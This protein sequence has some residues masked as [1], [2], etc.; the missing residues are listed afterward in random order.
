MAG[1]KEML[2]WRLSASPTTP[3]PVS[4]P[5]GDLFELAPEPQMLIDP[6][7]DRVL[8]ANAALRALVACDADDLAMLSPRRLVGEQ[9]ADLIVFTE[10]VLEKGQAWSDGL[11]CCGLDGRV[12][13]VEWR[14]VR[15]FTDQGIA[16][17]VA[18]R[19]I[20]QQQHRQAAAEANE[21]VRRGL[22]E[23]RRVER[24]FQEIEQ[25]NRLI[26]HAAGEGIYGVGADGSTTFVNPAAQ[27]ILGYRADELIGEN[28]HRMLHHTR[29]D[30][31]PYPILRLP[32]L[33]G[34]QGR[35]RAQ[36]RG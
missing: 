7:A 10:A 23:W 34:I 31:S 24:L 8:L 13:Q 19:D 22:S 3:A 14:A 11:Q 17:L 33:C 1:A 21:F 6:Y 27:R 35:H 4:L 2:A 25:E 32:H 26:L 12:R 30:G 9:V 28:M 29:A 15:V 16:M 5:V 36:G 18:V 20:D